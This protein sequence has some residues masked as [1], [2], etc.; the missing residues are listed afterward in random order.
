MLARVVRA[1][2]LHVLRSPSLYIARV[3]AFIVLDTAAA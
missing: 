2:H 1:P 3:I